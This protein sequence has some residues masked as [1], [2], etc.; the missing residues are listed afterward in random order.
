MEW[1]SVKERMPEPE[2]PVLVFDDFGDMTTAYLHNYS[3]GTTDW[4]LCETGS[5]ADDADVDGTVTHWM[6]LPEPPK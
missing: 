6:P 2:K 3:W 5:Y 1:I 4:H